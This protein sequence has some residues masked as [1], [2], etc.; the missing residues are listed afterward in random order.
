MI[1]RKQEMGILADFREVLTGLKHKKRGEATVNACP[2]CE[3][4]QI[5]LSS[6]FD[7]YPRMYGITPRKYVCKE[8][9]YTGPIVLE[10]TQEETG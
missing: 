5:V 3:S 1:W 10:Q 9:G 6:G 4:K 7:T 2:K 8:C